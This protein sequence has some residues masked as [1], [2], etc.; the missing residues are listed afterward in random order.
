MMHMNK[1]HVE[2]LAKDRIS[3]FHQEAAAR[4]LVRL[5]RGG[6]E[7]KGVKLHRRPMFQLLMLLLDFHLKSSF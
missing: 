3:G 2:F 4:G 5:S 1:D 6:R 7:H